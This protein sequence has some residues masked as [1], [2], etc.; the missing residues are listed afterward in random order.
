MQKIVASSLSPVG[1]L[2]FQYGG[3]LKNRGDTGD[4]VEKQPSIYLNDTKYPVQEVPPLSVFPP[5][6]RFPPFGNKVSS[7]A[8]QCIVALFSLCVRH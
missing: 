5:S 2:G 3:S 6:F 1:L 7:T 8:G 4:E